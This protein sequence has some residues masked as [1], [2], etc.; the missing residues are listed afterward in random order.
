MNI[1]NTN[2]HMGQTVT[3]GMIQT[4]YCQTILPQVCPTCGH[5]PTCGRGNATLPAYSPPITW[6]QSTSIAQPL[7]QTYN[8]P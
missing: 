3:G 4:G 5:C 7:A 1:D 6:G 8:K 2:D